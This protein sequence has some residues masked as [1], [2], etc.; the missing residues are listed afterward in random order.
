MA[1]QAR[2][3]SHTQN[4]LQMVRELSSAK[5]AV[6][7]FKEKNIDLK[8][9]AS[10]FKASLAAITETLLGLSNSILDKDSGAIRGFLQD[11]GELAP[12]LKKHENF[13]QDTA[14]E[15]AAVT[16]PAESE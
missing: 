12:S 13:P 5:K 1:N 16:T 7:D 14:E 4:N 15:Q 6:K 11:V 8:K 10:E 3:Q 9:E 2:D